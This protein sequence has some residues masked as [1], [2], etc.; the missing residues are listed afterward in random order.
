[1]FPFNLLLPWNVQAFFFQYEDDENLSNTRPFPK[2][3]PKKRSTG[4][5]GGSNSGST[6]YKFNALYG[7]DDAN[8]NSNSSNSDDSSSDSDEDDE[9]WRKRFSKTTKEAFLNTASSILLPS[10]PRESELRRRYAN[11]GKSSKNKIQ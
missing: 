3:L 6:K 8:D 9:R 10:M 5:G 7:S 1:M 2:R 4:S 11:T